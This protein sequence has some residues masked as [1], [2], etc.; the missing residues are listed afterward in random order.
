MQPQTPTLLLDNLADTVQQYP[1]GTLTAS[2]ERPGYE[3]DRI[4]DYRRERTSW[5]ASAAATAHQIDIDLGAGVSRAVD[6]LYLDRGHNLNGTTVSVY[7][8]ADGSAYTS[9]VARA[10]PAAGTLG[11]DPT[12]GVCVTEEGAAYLFFPLTAAHRYWR[13][14][15]AQASTFQAVVPGVILGKKL[16]LINFSATFD[17]DQGERTQPTQTATA[18]YRGTDTTY[19]WRLIELDLRYVGGPEYDASI[20]A[21]RALLFERNAPWVCVMDYGNYPERAWMYQYDGTTW[22]MPKTR[23]YRAGRIRGREVGASLP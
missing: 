1:L 2:S 5:Q 19:A 10:V 20:R 3:V 11:G 22:A 17:E 18:G 6:S 9:A 13:I 4:A 8:S 12:T 14:S 21:A 7:S 23:V 15:V 16:Q